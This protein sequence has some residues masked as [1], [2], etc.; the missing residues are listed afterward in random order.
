[1]N[2]KATLYIIQGFI[3]A[4]KSTFSRKLAKETGAIHFN[5]DEWVK[6]LFSQDEYMSEWNKCFEFTTHNLWEKTKEC[7]KENKD[8]IF[9]MGFWLKKD[10]DFAREIAKE[11]NADLKHY[12][13]YV[14][15][16]ILK[17]RIISDRPTHWAK[18]HLENFE[19]N[20][21]LFEEPSED[22]NVVIVMN[23]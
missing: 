15:D 16:D 12:Y 9:D 17:Q 5:P 6:D 18:M 23:Y 7:L 1:M 20:K 10:R 4:G 2:K 13:L 8:V 22:E 3:G 14:P 11:C 19:K 21:A